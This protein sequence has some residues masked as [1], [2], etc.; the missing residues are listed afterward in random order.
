MPNPSEQE[1]NDL[2]HLQKEKQTLENEVKALKRERY[3]LKLENDALKEALKL[4]KI[5]QCINLRTMKNRE[6]AMVIDAL[7]DRYPLKELLITFRMAK[8]SY[9][10]Q[11]MALNAPDKYKD[12]RDELRSIFTDSRER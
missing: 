1:A 4:L 3:K 9:C 5:A 11:E 2:I 7:R 6:K 12:L 10:Y 8:S